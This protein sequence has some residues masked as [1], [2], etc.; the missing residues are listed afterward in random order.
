MGEVRRYRKT[1]STA[2]TSSCRRSPRP[3]WPPWHRR[4]RPWA[5]GTELPLTPACGGRA[6]VTRRQTEG[7]YFM[8]SSP[9][10]RDLRG[11][12]P[13]EMLALSGFVLTPQCRPVA[14]ALVDLWHAN[15]GGDYDNARLPAFAAINSP[16]S[17]AAISSSPAS[18]ALSWPDTAF[19]RE[20]PGQGAGRSD[21]AAL[22]SGRARQCA[23]RHLRPRPADAI[24]AAEGGRLGRFDFVIAA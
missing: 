15:A 19:P 16:T 9:L 21:D 23:R 2:A 11:D 8:P 18:R 3:G 7:P 5:Q 22:F 17:R 1:S 13:G 4:G 12:G 10:K 20:G 6:P 14:G 24:R